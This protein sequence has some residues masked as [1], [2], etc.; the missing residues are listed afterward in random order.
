[1]KKTNE[2]KK[3]LQET[4]SKRENW[5]KHITIDGTS[6]IYISATNELRYIC[7]HTSG[8]DTANL[9]ACFVGNLLI[10]C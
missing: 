5:N 2:L 8:F 9:L 3:K 6:Y 4:F 1:M 10:W 7:K